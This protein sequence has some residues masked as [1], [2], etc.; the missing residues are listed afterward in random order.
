MVKSTGS[1]D[2]VG[3]GWFTYY[4]AKMGGFN[5]LSK[6]LEVDTDELDSFYNLS[7][8]PLYDKKPRSAYDEKKDKDTVEILKEKQARRD[9]F[10]EHLKQVVQDGSWVIIITEHLKTKENQTDFHFAYSQK[11][12]VDATINDM[13][14]YQRLFEQ[15][16]AAMKTDFGLDSVIAS[17]RYPLLK[18]NLGYTIRKDIANANVFVVRPSSELVNFNDRKLA[19]AYRMASVISQQLDGGRGIQPDDVKDIK[20]TGFGYGLA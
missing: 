13:E 16:D 10:E 11:G 3:M 17:P 1:F 5:Y 19:I 14:A 4:L 6:E 9:K 20:E 12:G 7:E 15:F 18:K 8:K 2:E